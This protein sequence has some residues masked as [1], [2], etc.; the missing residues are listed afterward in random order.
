M[1]SCGICG[2]TLGISSTP[3]GFSTL[4]V[5]C[6]N[7]YFDDGIVMALVKEGI[8]IAAEKPF[9]G[10]LFPDWIPQILAG[11]GKIKLTYENQEKW[12]E[13]I[14][15]AAASEQA[16]ELILEDPMA[17]MAMMEGLDG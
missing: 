15:H 16:R 1:A 12:M 3:D 11:L 10:D 14:R 8:V 2:V 7:D 9:E 5:G 13:L 17:A 4:H 6:A